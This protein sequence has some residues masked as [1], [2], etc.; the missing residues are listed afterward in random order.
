MLPAAL[1]ARVETL[2]LSAAPEWRA[3]NAVH[4]LARLP[5]ALTAA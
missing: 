5:L 2:A 1:L 3:G 4:T